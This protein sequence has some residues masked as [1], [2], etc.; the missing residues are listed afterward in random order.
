MEKEKTYNHIHFSADVLSAAHQAFLQ[1]VD[2]EKKHKFS[3]RLRID[4][5][6]ATWTLDTMEEF[7]ADYRRSRG[8]VSFTVEPR[9][10]ASGQLR[11]TVLGSG[12]HRNTVVEVRASD[13][14]KIE[15]MFD[16]FERHVDESRLPIERPNPLQTKPTIFIGHG[17]SPV[18]RDLKDHLQDKHD[19]KVEA[20]EVG[21]R[22]GHGIR[23]ILEEMLNKSTFA[24]LVMTGEDETIDN[25]FQPRLN[26]VHELGLFQGRLGFGRAI[27]LFEKETQG[28]SNIQGIQ[29][30]RFSKNNIRETFGDVLATLNR[31]FP[32]GD[33]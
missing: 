9:G 30:I 2:P 1:Q 13:R 19:Y 16:V 26:V 20:Y 27:M 32:R 23:D 15:A 24:I 17:Q 4:I 18:W 29:Q 14:P 3:Y 7:I 22:A 11:V 5:D 6:G 25:E 28:F 21:A 8:W 10:D 31:E 12:N 33:D